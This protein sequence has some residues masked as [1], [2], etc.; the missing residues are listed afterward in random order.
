MS[1]INKAKQHRIENYNQDN[2]N[3]YRLARKFRS[4]FNFKGNKVIFREDEDEVRLINQISVQ[5]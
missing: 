2:Y 5:E 4:N 1:F 3:L